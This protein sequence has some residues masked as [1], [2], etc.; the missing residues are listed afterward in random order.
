MAPVFH[1]TVGGWAE[2]K[3][4]ILSDLF[5]NSFEVKKWSP[6]GDIFTSEPPLQKQGGKGGG[7][8]IC[9]IQSHTVNVLHTETKEDFFRC[10]LANRGEIPKW[11]LCM[12]TSSLPLLSVDISLLKVFHLFEAASVK[13]RFL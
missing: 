7:E 1:Q 8:Q 13:K 11:C 6:E 2:D 12:L 4:K 5:G 10:F 3:E 9:R